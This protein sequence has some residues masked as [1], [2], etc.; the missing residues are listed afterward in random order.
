VNA[1]RR[2]EAGG[3][4]VPARALR[5]AL[6]AACLSAL[7]G[8]I[9]SQ[10]L[11]EAFDPCAPDGCQPPPP[12][13]C[14]TLSSA[15]WEVWGPSSAAETQVALGA[16]LQTTLSPSVETHCR[17]AVS[18]VEWH[19]D[20]PTIVSL[21]PDALHV[22]VTGRALGATSVGAVKPLHGTFDN[23]RTPPGDFTVRIDNLGP[24]RETAR[25]EIRLTPS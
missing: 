6:A 9:D 11:R 20:D 1:D 25:Y 19:A 5:I 24:G 7:A 14:A 10:K 12:Q 15:S 23:P 22:W 3:R 2:A 8:C 17:G 4:P 21:V 16:S 13:N 18:S